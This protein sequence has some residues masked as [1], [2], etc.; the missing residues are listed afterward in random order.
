[1]EL[2]SFAATDIGR[3]RKTNEDSYLANDDLAMYVVADGMGGHAAGEVASSEA[4]DA[5]SSLTTS[6]RDLIEDFKAGRI[7]VDEGIRKISRCVE[8]AIQSAAYMVHGLAQIDEQKSGMGTTIS[9]L[10]IV[11]DY[12][13]TGQ[14]GDSRVYYIRNRQAVQLT[15]DHTLINWQLKEGLLTP[16]QAAVAKHR[17]VVTRAV[18]SRDYVQVDVRN[19]PVHSGDQFMLCSDGLYEYITPHEIAAVL[20]HEPESAV[21]HLIEMALS[22]GGKDNATSIV[23]RI[24]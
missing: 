21:R 12:G 6:E 5:I 24:K 19:F 15:E 3:K 2:I 17:N 10:M 4:I 9:A 8:S 22:R 13:L 7:D 14:V 20:E 11:G 23:V 16:E 1:M 18:G